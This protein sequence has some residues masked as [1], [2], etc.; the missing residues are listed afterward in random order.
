MGA[1]LVSASCERTNAR[2][3]TVVPAGRYLDAGEGRENGSVRLAGAVAA[4]VGTGLEW[5]F[6]RRIPVAAAVA[7]G[8]QPQRQHR[9]DEPRD[10]HRPLPCEF[11]ALYAILRLMPRNR[12][13]HHTAPR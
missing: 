11:R 6:E 13:S 10:P 4:D 5:V 3:G 9:K 2:R 8:E 1:L 12:S 7:P